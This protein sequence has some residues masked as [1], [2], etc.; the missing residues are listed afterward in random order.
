MK[1]FAGP[2]AL[3]LALSSPLAIAHEKENAVELGSTLESAQASL[4][5]LMETRLDG[6]PG[7][8]YAKVSF[9]E[10]GLTLEAH[11][12]A[13]TSKG[14]LYDKDILERQLPYVEGYINEAFL[15]FDSAAEVLPTFEGQN[16]FYKGCAHV[17]RAYTKLSIARQKA[18]RSVVFQAGDF[19]ALEADLSAALVDNDCP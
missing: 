14:N 16:L 1:K 5:E 3:L 11:V 2:L 13:P 10:D 9:Y 18:K 6:T 4:S 8:V 15:M 19:D 17:R 7:V 12:L